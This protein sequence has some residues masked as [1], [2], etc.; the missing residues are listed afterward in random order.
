MR[1]CVDLIKFVLFIA[2]FLCFLAFAG[3]LAGTVYILLNGQNTFIGQHIEPS[4]SSDDPTNATYF[5]FIVIFIVVFSFFAIFTCLGCCG[6][7]YKSGCMLGSFIII[8]FVL[9]GGSVGA[10]VFL[11]TQFGWGAVLEVL[12]QEMSRNLP[13]YKKD[14]VFT[15]RFW[16]W[17]QNTFGCCGVEKVDGW[18]IWSTS[19]G[20]KSNW[21]VPES[22]CRDGEEDCMYEPNTETIYMEGCAPKVVLYVQIIFY[23]VPILMFVSLVFAFIVSSSVSNSERRRKAV[24]NQALPYRAHSQFN[25]GADDDFQHHHSYTSAPMHAENLPYNPHYEQEMLAYHQHNQSGGSYGGGHIGNYPTGTV[26]PPTSHMPLLHQ[27]P[28][29]YNEVVNRK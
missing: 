29:S 27:A 16:N 4:L 17:I 26:P 22:C 9:F 20:L 23:G 6:T 7:A 14:N 15:F 21:K 3:L 13:T 12:I 25:I 24:S 28:P 2:N 11:H 1:C 10:V 19:E 8:L 18:K 5:S